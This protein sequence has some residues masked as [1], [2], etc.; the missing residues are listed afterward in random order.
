[1]VNSGNISGGA[2]LIG[3]GIAGIVFASSDIIYEMW[4]NGLWPK[5]NN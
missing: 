1:M 3:L 2:V 4:P 5:S